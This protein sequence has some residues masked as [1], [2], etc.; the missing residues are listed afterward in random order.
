MKR[1]AFVFCLILFIPV[2]SITTIA[3]PDPNLEIEIRGVLSKNIVIN[4]NFRIIIENIGDETALGTECDIWVFGGI[5]QNARTYWGLN[6]GDISSGTSRIVPFHDF[7]LP[8]FGIIEIT[9]QVQAENVESI[10]MSIN[11]IAFGLIWII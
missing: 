3:D 2:F 4:R 5:R 10:T 6:I 1:T 8:F 11:A 9:V 7:N